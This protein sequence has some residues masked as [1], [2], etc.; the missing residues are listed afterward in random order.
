MIEGGVKP[1]RKEKGKNMKRTIFLEKGTVVN[2]VEGYLVADSKN[3][4]GLIYFDEYTIDEDGNEVKEERQR[5]L[6]RNEVADIMKEVDGKNHH[7]Y[8]DF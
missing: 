7:V 5:A 1:P 6:T 3:N 8:T 2:T 4:G